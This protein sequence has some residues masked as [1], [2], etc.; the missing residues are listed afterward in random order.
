MKIAI[1]YDSK[2]GNTQRL[3]EA[4]EEGVKKEGF[5]TELRKIGEKFPLSLIG[6]VDAVIFGSPVI[7]ANITNE[8]REFLQ[9]LARFTESGKFDVSGRTAAVFGSYGYDGAWIMQDLFKVLVESLGYS[10]YDKVH[11]EIDTEIRYN[12]KQALERAE[13][14][15]QEFAKTLQQ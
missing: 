7:Y 10:V 9:H 5:E 11:A 13:K 8:A 1:V 4:I 12:T 14:F 15:G 2:S 6:E 3:A